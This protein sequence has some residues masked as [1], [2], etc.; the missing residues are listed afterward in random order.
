[1]I[2]PRFGDRVRIAARPETE[3]TGFA[4]RVG[5]VWGESVPSVS[6]VGPVIGDRGADLALSVFFEDSEDVAWFAPHLVQCVDRGGSRSPILPLVFLAALVLAAATALA[7]IGNSPVRRLTVVSATTPCLP[8]RGYL[9]TGAYPNVLGRSMRAARTNIALRRAV[10]T[11]ERRYAPSAREHS[12][13]DWNGIY[14]TA[15]DQGLTS[16]STVVVSALIPVLRLYPG[17]NDGQTWISTTVDVRSGRAV[18]LR[19]L[20]ANPS[21]A[22]PVL[23]SD[24]K[25]RLRN[26]V[27][28]PSVAGDSASYTPS[29]AH[30]RYF[31]L[32]PTGLAFGFAQEPAGPRLAAVIP[33]RLVRPYLSP[34]GRRLVAGVRRPRPARNQAQAEFAGIGPRH[35]RPDVTAGWPVT[36]T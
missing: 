34:L 20:L 22:L 8:V 15:I 16:A 25:S 18:S 6:D 32:T 17:G 11:D 5:E 33:Y 19:Q 21:L 12:F 26:S 24:W 30:Y 27:L 36:C 10:V 13:G 3:A 4:G 29:F 14:Q 23:A 31:S 7:G 1:M 2:S 28:W 35:S 9:T